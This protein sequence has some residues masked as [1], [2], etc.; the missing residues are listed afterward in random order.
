MQSLSSFVVSQFC[1]VV[2][3]TG[4]RYTL[5]CLCLCIGGKVGELVQPGG[6]SED[7]LGLRL[8]VVGGLVVCMLSCNSCHIYGIWRSRE[9]EKD[10]NLS[11]RVAMQAIRRDNF[12]QKGGFS[13]ITRDNFYQKE[14][15]SLCNTAVL[16]LYFN[17]DWVLLIILQ[18]TR[19]LF[20]LYYCC[21]TYFVSI[22]IG[23]TKSAI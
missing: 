8:A 6:A 2:I 11:F 9:A 21:F 16:K 7:Y 22:E 17:F 14:G 10:L 19:Y 3:Q 4:V 12:H 18:D 20:S 13:L 5:K 15:F 23:K 1:L